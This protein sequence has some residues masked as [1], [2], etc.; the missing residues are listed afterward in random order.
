MICAERN[1][2]THTYNENTVLQN[3]KADML[4]NILAYLV[5]LY[6]DLN[7]RLEENVGPCKDRMA[8]L[9]KEKDILNLL[10]LDL[11]RAWMSMRASV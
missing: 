10:I 6:S 3:C 2:H 4:T 7:R 8:S 1:F 11:N 9:P 5:K